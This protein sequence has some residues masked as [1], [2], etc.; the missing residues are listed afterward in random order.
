MSGYRPESLVVVAE[1][2]AFSDCREILDKRLGSD[3]V[4][5]EPLCSGS[6]RIQELVRLSCGEDKH[7]VLRRL[8]KRLEQG[9][10]CSARKHVGLI[11]DVH[12]FCASGCG[13][14]SNV[15]PDLANVLDLVM[16][17]RIEFDDID[18]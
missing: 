4:E 17:R 16:R 7:D 6:N 15:D 18:G 13:N 12:T 9:V 3:G 1:T 2:L 8:L 14:G 5:V 11:K 10:T